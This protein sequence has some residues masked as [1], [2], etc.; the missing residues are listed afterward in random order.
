MQ[1][2]FRYSLAKLLQGSPKFASTSHLLLLFF[3][4]GD[5]VSFCRP[6][7]SACSGTISVHYN[8]HLPGS[9]DSP[10]SAFPVAGTTGTRHHDRL[11][12]CI[13]S[14][15]WVSS[16]WPGWFRTPGLK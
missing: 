15:D 11:S 10:A 9:N 6:G 14:R 16:C 7:R 12:F 5:R 2:H 3:F 1:R 13:F 8:L 4:F